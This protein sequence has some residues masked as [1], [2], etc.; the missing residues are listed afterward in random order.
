MLMLAFN[1]VYSWPAVKL[2]TYSYIVITKQFKLK[3]NYCVAL[4]HRNLLDTEPLMINS[5]HSIICI[6]QSRVHAYI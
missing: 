2:V 3:V 6:I 5:M 1:M 4:Y